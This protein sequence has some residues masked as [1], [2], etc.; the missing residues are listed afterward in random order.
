[1]TEPI[2]LH[3]RDSLPAGFLRAAPADLHRLLPGPTLIHLDGG[4]GAPL[5]IALLQHGNESS[6]LNTVQELLAAEGN[7]ALPRPVSLFV[8]NVEAA[9]AGVRRLDHQPDYN[10]CWP[11]TE[12]PDCPETRMLAEVVEEM[13][14]RRPL[15]AIDLH[16]TTGDN[17]LHAGLN[18]LDHRCLW[19]AARFA[20]TAVHFTRPR[21][22]MP[23]A[24]TDLCPALLLECGRPGDARGIAAATR[25]LRQCLQLDAVP[26]EVP[27]PHALAL[28]DS[29]ALVFIPDSVRFAFGDAAD[30]DLLLRPD[31]DRWNFVELEA[32]TVFGHARGNYWPVRALA[33]D[34]REITGEVFALE[35]GQLRLRRALM[36]GLLT[37]DERIIRQD[38]LCHLMERIPLPNRAGAPPGS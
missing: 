13:R 2:R 23:A 1:M 16:N 7:D 22:A 26:S 8:A 31:I 29:T 25:F 30:A 15:A 19:L 38:C 3:R 34:G 17:P 4:T 24:F 6:G 5:F 28:F 14:P 36:P 37:G 18:V 12:E 27:G 33:P 10:R 32:G 21:G 9:R 11:G 20:D 35:D